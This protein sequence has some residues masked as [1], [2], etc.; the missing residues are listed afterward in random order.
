MF[1]PV[2]S[3]DI[4]INSLGLQEV[5]VNAVNEGFGFVDDFAFELIDVKY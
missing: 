5:I 2:S 3:G 1:M 4:S